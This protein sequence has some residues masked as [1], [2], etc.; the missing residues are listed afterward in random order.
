MLGFGLLDANGQAGR[1]PKCNLA[2]S[3]PAKFRERKHGSLEE[4]GRGDFNR[5][6]EAFRIGE[7][8]LAGARG[9]GPS[10]GEHKANMISWFRL[11]WT[12]QNNAYSGLY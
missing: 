3:A 1:R 11:C 4:R 8:D 12:Q 2:K 6:F 5:V 7:R 10:I 9:H